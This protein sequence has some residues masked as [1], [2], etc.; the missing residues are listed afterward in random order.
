MSGTGTGKVIMETTQKW[1]WM[2]AVAVAK[3]IPVFLGLLAIMYAVG[4][5]HAE[6]L[7]KQTVDGRATNL[8][9]AFR[10]YRVET[11]KTTDE[12]RKEQKVYKKERSKKLDEAYSRQGVIIEK[13]RQQEQRTTEQRHDIKE[14]LRLL[15]ARR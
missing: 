1:S 5:P 14:I 15:R 7:I 13:Q 10:D 9:N 4:K 6:N 12:Y 8:E 2:S 3:G 11:R